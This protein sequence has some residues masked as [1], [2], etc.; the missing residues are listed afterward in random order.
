MAAIPLDQHGHPPSCP[1]L[2]PTV[3]AIIFLE[4]SLSL[5]RMMAELMAFLV[6]FD[7]IFYYCHRLLHT[8][9][10]YKYFL[11]APIGV[12]FAQCPND[13]C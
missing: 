8:R 2:L 11:L 7:T 9:N 4:P 1:S 3:A 10:F 5:S 13:I 12:P 6:I